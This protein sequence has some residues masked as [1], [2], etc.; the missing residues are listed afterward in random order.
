M[1]CWPKI[2][3]QAACAVTLETS[4]SDGP[5]SP[6]AG[7]GQQSNQSAVRTLQ[8]KICSA[9]LKNLDELEYFGQDKNTLTGLTL[10]WGHLINSVRLMKFHVSTQ[11]A[12]ADG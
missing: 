12:E 5:C 1:Q 3:L 4:V 10:W 2:S 7:H 6:E 9:A 11:E 8:C